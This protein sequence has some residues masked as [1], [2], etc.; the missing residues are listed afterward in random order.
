M[1]RGKGKIPSSGSA[2]DIL[3]N[4]NLGGRTKVHETDSDFEIDDKE[5]NVDNLNLS[6]AKK[7]NPNLKIYS[8][9]KLE[10]IR[11]NA[12][13]A[14]NAQERKLERLSELLD[15]KDIRDKAS[16][17]IKFA[18]DIDVSPDD[19]Y[20]PRTKVL[21]QLFCH[22]I[23]KELGHLPLTYAA[24]NNSLSYDIP[25]TEDENGVGK[26]ILINN[27]ADLGA[28]IEANQSSNSSF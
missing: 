3:F 13:S 8:N 26:K 14:K 7:K 24:P 15:S 5:I 23:L 27:L 1:G 10:D 17:K 16:A 19:W 25:G 2:K 6:A 22:I 20:L 21:S 28:A 9:P 18:V 4:S 11:N 12:L